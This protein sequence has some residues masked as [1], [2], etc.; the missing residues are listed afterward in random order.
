MKKTKSSIITL[1]AIAAMTFSFIYSHHK[2]DSISGLTK[3]NI[4]ALSGNWLEEWWNRN[5]YT[6]VEI[7]CQCFLYS[8]KSDTAAYAGDGKGEEAHTWNCTGC[9]DGCGWT[10]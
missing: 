8:Y 4:E 10:K 2:T 6:C 9:A 5:D 7:T 1:G 3:E